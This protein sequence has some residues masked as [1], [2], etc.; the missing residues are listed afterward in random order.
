MPSLHPQQRR[1]GSV[2]GDNPPPRGLWYAA[3]LIR[4]AACGWQMAQFYKCPIVRYFGPLGLLLLARLCNCANHVPCRCCALHLL[5]GSLALYAWQPQTVK[6]RRCG[7]LFSTW[8]S[9]CI[10]GPLGGVLRN[11]P[12]PYLGDPLT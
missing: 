9:L 10:G 2:S 11:E 12:E 6:D 1:F 4:I 5:G 8:L 7:P 3:Y